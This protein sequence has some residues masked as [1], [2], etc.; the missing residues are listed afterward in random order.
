MELTAE[1]GVNEVQLLMNLIFFLLIFTETFSLK[2]VDEMQQNLEQPGTAWN[3]LEQGPD[4]AGLFHTVSWLLVE[5]QE[6]VS[7]WGE[8]KAPDERLKEVSMLTA[9]C[10]ERGRGL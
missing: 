3:S 7:V 8:T 10:L 9:S 4:T 2:V 1:L 5:L 6:F